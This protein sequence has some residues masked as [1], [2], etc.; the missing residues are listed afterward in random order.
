[1]CHDTTAS[2]TQVRCYN[3]GQ[4]SHISKE[5]TKPW[6]EKGSCYKCGKKDHLIK[7]CLITQKKKATKVKQLERRIWQVAK[8]EEEPWD[9]STLIDLGEEEGKENFLLGDA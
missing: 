3:C 4:L 5:C 2:A 8:V 6:Q 1:M 9:D 7:D